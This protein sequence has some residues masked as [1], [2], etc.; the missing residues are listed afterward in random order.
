MESIGQWTRQAKKRTQRSRNVALAREIEGGD[1]NM[2]IVKSVW[3]FS[4][5]YAR[6]TW[7]IGEALPRTAVSI[8]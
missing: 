7:A 4:L 2:P 3:K 6:I 1:A 8:G 5:G